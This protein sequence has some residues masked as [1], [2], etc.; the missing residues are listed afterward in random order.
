M[1]D[2]QGKQVKEAGPSVPV[3]VLGLSGVPSAGDVLTVV[4][5]E[6]RAREVAAYRQ[7]L[8][9]RKRPTSAADQPGEHV[10]LARQTRRRNSPWSSRPDVQ[11]IGGGYFQRRQPHLDR[12]HQG[13]H[14]SSGVGAI[15]E[16]DVVLAAAS[17]APIIG[18]NV[19]PTPRR[20][21]WRPAPR[22][23]SAITTSSTTSPIG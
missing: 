11:G 22:S 2:D 13:A 21:K 17:G 5:N 9:D 6:A 1:I 10:R 20:A 16:S 12:G 3:E 19:R 14:P 18:F 23:S 8:L 7:G 4:E 15:T